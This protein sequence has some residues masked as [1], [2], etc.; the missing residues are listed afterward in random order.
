[1]F[2][3]TTRSAPPAFADSASAPPNC[4]ICTPLDS[5]AALVCA[6]PL[7]A[8]MSTSS[9]R[10]LKM[11]F[12]NAYHMTQSSALTLLYAAMTFLQHAIAVSAGAPDALAATDVAGVGDAPDGVVPPHAATSS[13]MTVTKA[14]S[15]HLMLSLRVY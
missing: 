14:A 12:S 10:S 7:I 9:P 15:L 3:T 13:P 11:P 2:A 1:M 6:P 8:C 5:R 4:A